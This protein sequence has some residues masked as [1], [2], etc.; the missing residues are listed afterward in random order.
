MRLWGKVASG[1]LLVMAA[2]FAAV[3]VVVPEARHATAVAV[4]ILVTAAL[5]GVPAL[6]RL[7]SSFAGDE[8][9]LENGT[10]GVATITA[11]GWTGWRFNRSYP[12]V[13]FGLKVEAAGVYPVEIKQAVEPDLLAR[14]APGVVVG[15]RV[16]RSNRTHVVIDWRQPIRSATDAVAGQ[17]AAEATPTTVSSVERPA[18]RSPWPFLRWGFLLFGLIFLRL[19]CEEGYFE[20]GGTRVQGVVLQK[21]YSPGTTSTGGSRSSPARRTV[22]YRFTIKEGQT[23]EGRT[24]V[25]PGTWESLKQGGPVVVEYLPDSPDTSRILGQRA[26]SGTWAVMAAVLLTASVAL[27]IMGWGKRVAQ[28]PP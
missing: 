15:V 2:V 1:M 10:P 27:F 25:L 20:A 9:V 17:G 11:L 7:F 14:L 19:S 13:R 21:T 28:R 23:L 8:E 16:D 22:S 6:V 18:R 4:V 12:I 24:D 26:R 3:A 5:L